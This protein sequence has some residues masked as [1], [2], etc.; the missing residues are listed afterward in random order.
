[1][2]AS[3]KESSKSVSLASSMVPC[4]FFDELL[5]AFDFL[6]RVTRNTPSLAEL[7]ATRNCL[8]EAILI[9]SPLRRTE[10]SQFSKKFRKRR[11]TVKTFLIGV[12]HKKCSVIISPYFFYYL[13]ELGVHF[14]GEYANIFSIVAF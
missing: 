1:M 11:N 12:I 2:Q 13:L 14:D 10:N 7:R 5:S 4:F 6:W 9:R 3:N 8:S